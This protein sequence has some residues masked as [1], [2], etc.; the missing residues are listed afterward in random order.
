MI[1]LFIQSAYQDIVKTAEVIRATDLA[2]TI[3]RLPL[4]NSKP[5]QGRVNAGYMGEGKVNLPLSRADLV[6]FLLAQLEDDTFIQKAPAIS[7]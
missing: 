5:K 2:W 4:L 1:K 7:N 3:V 6:D